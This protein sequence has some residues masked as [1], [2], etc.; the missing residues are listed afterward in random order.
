[1][2]FLAQYR[3]KYR[4]CMMRFKT[5]VL[6]AKQCTDATSVQLYQGNCIFK[7]VRINLSHCRLTV[8][9]FVLRVNISFFVI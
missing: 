4:Y 6:C 7:L 2:G 9:H 8:F 5:R 1:M 3:D